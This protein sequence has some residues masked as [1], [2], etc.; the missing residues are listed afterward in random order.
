M[1]DPVTGGLIGAGFGILKHSMVDRP[2]FKEQAK[3]EA[4]KTAYAP[5]LGT[6]GDVS[7]KP[8]GIQSALDFGVKGAVLG[9]AL[10][11]E[12]AKK[13]GKEVAKKSIEGAS[14]KAA[15][16]GAAGSLNF[17]QQQFA[18]PE[19][20]TQYG[21]IGN[22]TMIDQPNMTVAHDPYADLQFNAP[23]S[24]PYTNAALPQQPQPSMSVA[25]APK[26]QFSDL[27]FN[28]PVP[29]GPYA[30]PPKFPHPWYGSP[31]QPKEDNSMQNNYMRFKG[32]KF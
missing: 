2:M 25:Q 4:M 5:I 1:I 18:A 16:S 27:N 11:G 28:A 12:A 8:S 24:T 19:A 21:A 9:K 31:F 17:G 6:M 26:D 15:A 3:V 20:G 23:Q 22:Q 14:K 7:K 10:G 30:Q 29:T 32:G 13:A